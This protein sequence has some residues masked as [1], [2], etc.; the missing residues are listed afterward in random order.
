MSRLAL[1]LTVPVLTL[2][3]LVLSPGSAADEATVERSISFV[4]THTGETISVVYKRDGELVPD[5]LARLNRFL[6]DH[7]TGDV[8]EVDPDVFDFLWE[9]RKEVGSDEPFHLVSGYRSPVTNE[10]LRRAGRKI[11]KKSLH[12]K[13]QAIDFRLPGTDTARLRDVALALKRGGVGY[14]RESDFIHVDIGRVRRW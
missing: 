14:Y 4:H 7:R 10:K 8:H 11:G 6:R 2:A 13:G 1:L 9:I 3:A 12:V 5:A